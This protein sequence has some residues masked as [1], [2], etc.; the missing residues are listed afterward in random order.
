MFAYN[1]T[2]ELAVQSQFSKKWGFCLAKQDHILFIIN[3]NYLIR[4]AYVKCINQKVSNSKL[5]RMKKNTLL[6]KKSC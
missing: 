1:D 5:K 4:Y 3:W 2:K 6:F